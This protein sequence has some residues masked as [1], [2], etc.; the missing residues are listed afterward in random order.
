ME[1]REP[2]AVCANQFQKLPLDKV[3]QTHLVFLIDVSGSMDLPN[4]L[5][6]L[7]SGFKGLVNNLRPVDSVSIVVY[8]GSVGIA[9]P[10][11]SGGEKEKIFRTIDSLQPGGSTPGESGIRVRIVWRRRTI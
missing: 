4:R 1:Q 6:L 5:P 2:P 3:P 7:K 8:G 10:T 11:T 9:L